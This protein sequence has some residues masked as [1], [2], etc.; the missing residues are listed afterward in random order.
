MARGSKVVTLAGGV[1]SSN[2]SIISIFHYAECFFICVCLLTSSPF[3]NNARLVLWMLQPARW[4]KP[5]SHRCLFAFHTGVFLIPL[6]SPWELPSLLVFFNLPIQN[7]TFQSRHTFLRIVLHG[8]FLTFP[9]KKP[10]FIFSLCWKHLLQYVGKK[11]CCP[12]RPWNNQL[13]KSDQ[14]V[15]KLS[16]N[17]FTHMLCGLHISHLMYKRI[18]I[19]FLFFTPLVVVRPRLS[20]AKMV[21]I[22]EAWGLILGERCTLA[23]ARRT[24]TQPSGIGD[25][26]GHPPDYVGQKESCQSPVGRA[27]GGQTALILLLFC[28]FSTP[29]C[30]HGAQSDA[31]PVHLRS[32]SLSGFWKAFTPSWEMHTK[33]PWS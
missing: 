8:L 9:G 20:S 27:A 17:T 4:M 12:L 5:F 26:K 22:W 33:L 25:R 14:L 1:I 28:P 29:S 21:I 3:T 16:V 30:Q 31:A 13:Q 15:V 2:T 6:S 24:S 18:N 7:T 32:S 10:T 23:A 19:L 11:L